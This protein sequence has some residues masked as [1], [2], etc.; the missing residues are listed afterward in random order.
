MLAKSDKSITF[1]VI[2]LVVF[3]S[4]MIASAEMGNSV[5][6]TSYLT[7]VIL[8]QSLYA[9]VGLAL[10]FYLIVSK[11]VR[12]IDTKVCLIM[13]VLLAGAMVACRFFGQING[14][15][16]WIRFGE[17]TVQPS[18]F[19]KTFMI[20][21]GA[22]VLSNSDKKSY[23]TDYIIY[24][25]LAILYIIIIW[26]IQNDFGSAV[27]LAVICYC[28][29]L[30]PS[31]KEINDIRIK[32]FVLLALAVIG[33]LFLLSPFFT[34][35][36]KKH[37]DNYMAGRFLAAADPFLYRYDNGYHVIMALVSFANGNIFGLGY[38]NS[39]HKYMNFPNPSNDFI[40]PVIVEELG[41][42]GFSIFLIFYLI[43]LCQLMRWSYK[44]NNLASK[45]TLL[46]CFV[47]IITHFIL[48]VGGVSALI[49]LTGVPLLLISSGGSSLVSCLM[50]LGLAQSEI[51]DSRTVIHNES[52][53][54]QI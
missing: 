19:A 27:V 21:F 10:Y 24:L 50:A 48:N 12:K 36:V 53:S 13:Y 45:I 41:I 37:A 39:I 54:R 43:I 17:L 34:E 33:V 18:E 47:Y 49:P 51:A 29:L 28:I 35:F 31:R 6:D 16:A 8:K 4:L 3:G 14:A 52:N 1:S 32:L 15:Y 5:G 30:I 44:I 2:I 40:L 38:G 20:F 25:C 9:I 7:G 26:L 11:L 42:V 46:G 22:K 23:R